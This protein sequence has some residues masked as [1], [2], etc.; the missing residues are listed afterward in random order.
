[1]KLARRHFL[2]LAA[3]AAG[4]AGAAALPAFPDAAA[5]L[6]YPTRPVHMIVDLPAGLAPDVMARLV[7]APLSERLGQPIVIENR[8]GAGGNIGAEVV[9]R[10]PPDG[11]TLLAMIS[12]NAASGALYPNLDFN[13]IRDI[14]AVAFLGYTPFTMVV[15]PSVPAKTVAEFIAYAKAN[16]AKINWA[17]PGTGTAPH[18]AGELFQ[19]MT[20]VKLVHVPY[21]GNYMSDLL[22]GH[23]QVAFISIPPVLG[24]IKSG[25]LRALAVTTRSRMGLLP[26]IPT[27]AESVPGYEGSGWAGV[28]APKGTP[29]DI[30]DKLNK[31]INAV[32]AEPAIKARLVNMGVELELMTPEQFGK[33]IA[34]AAEKWAKVIKF[35]NIKA[36]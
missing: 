6:D 1:M 2:H 7:S 5:A 9:V 12:G 13:F 17:S 29:A 24:Y 4:A 31:D 3:G 14:A 34:D 18:L 8:P 10:A 30:I 26:E 15:N 20:G 22:A 23:V 33:L 27:V 11:Y 36:K 16:P 21:R 25:K 28:G 32:L 19:M 35:A